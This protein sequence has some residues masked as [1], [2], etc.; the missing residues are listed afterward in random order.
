MQESTHKVPK[1]VSKEVFLQ[2]AAPPTFPPNTSRRFALGASNVCL[3][4]E[5]PR[6]SVPEVQGCEGL[7][8]YDYGHA[9]HEYLPHRCYCCYR[10]CYCFL[11]FLCR[12][13]FFLF[14]CVCWFCCFCVI[15]CLSVWYCC[16]VLTFVCLFVCW[17]V[18]LL[19]SARVRPGSSGDSGGWLRAHSGDMRGAKKPIWPLPVHDLGEALQPGA[20]YIVI[21]NVHLDI[22]SLSW[23]ENVS[24]WWGT[25]RIRRVWFACIW[26][27]FESESRPLILMI[28]IWIWGLIRIWAFLFLWICA[29][30]CTSVWI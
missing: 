1:S 29:W 11:F 6:Y 24:S 12:W 14:P 22:C 21:C 19:F 15:A 7:W 20:S 17:V 26:S 4:G 23:F 16:L 10:G 8:S 30:I 28:V 3:I 9:W 25:C 13:V 18:C 5:K 27:W 2:E